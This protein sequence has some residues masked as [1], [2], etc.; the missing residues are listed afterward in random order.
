MYD[1]FEKDNKKFPDMTNDIKW[2]DTKKLIYFYGIA[3]G[4]AYLHSHN[5]IHRNLKPGNILLDEHLY[6]KISGFDISKEIGKK[7]FSI[8]M[9]MIGTP[10]YLAPEIYMN[11]EYSKSSD[12]YSFGL[13]IYEILSGEKPFTNVISPKGIKQ[14]IL[15][16]ESRPQIPETIC[17]SY[18]NLIERCWSQKPELRPTF[19]T[20]VDELRTNPSFITQD[21]DEDE[22]RKYI[23]YIDETP[24]S[25][26][27]LKKLSYVEHSMK[28]TDIKFKERNLKINLG[29]IYKTELNGIQVEY[30][31]IDIK[32]YK[33]EKLLNFNRK[34][35]IYKISDK[36][37]GK[38]YQAV[39][40]CQN[41]SLNDNLLCN[42]INY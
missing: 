38:F 2:D 6:P 16:E 1:F 39:K 14:I 8:N 36:Q 30:D 33:K 29:N 37:T 11:K 35:K 3:S 23:K 41:I 24:N 27:P 40:R 32:K 42:D 19:E 15:D 12:V 31:F 10:A 34:N 9:N 22:Y 7:T 18:R 13:I 4:M 25:F 28:R 26:D 17:E 21:V 20:I 5:I